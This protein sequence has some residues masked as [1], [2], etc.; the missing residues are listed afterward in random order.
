MTM[1]WPLLPL[2]LVI[3]GYAAF[4]LRA[5]SQNPI[6]R[7]FACY[8]ATSALWTIGIAGVYSGY[9]VWISGI[10]TFASSTLIP[11]SML[12]F[13][14]HYP[15]RSAA[16]SSGLRYLLWTV[17]GS[18][19]VLSLTTGLV[20]SDVQMV[21]G[22]PRRI[23]GTLHPL[24]AVYFVITSVI[25]FYNLFSKWRESR[26]LE[27]VQLTYLMGASLLSLAG[28]MVTNLIH[29]LVAGR[30]NYGWLGPYFSLVFIGV[31]GHAVVRHRLFDIRLVIHKGLTFAVAIV[32]SLVPVAALLII[33][34]RRLSLH[35]TS[36]ELTVG[37]TVVLATSLIIP[38]TRDVASRL[39]NRYVYRREANY[40]RTVR[41]ASRALTRVLQLSRLV[42]FM[43][44]TIA[45]AVECEGVSLYVRKGQ[46]LQ[47]G[48]EEWRHSGAQFE[49]PIK[50][51]SAILS[52]LDV[53]KD[54]VVTDEL[55]RELRSPQATAVHAELTRLDW[56]LVLPAVSENTVIGAIVLGPKRSG[57][58]Y[59]PHDLDLLMTLANQ[60]GIA[61]KNA[62]LYAQVVLANEYLENILATID[63]GVVAVDADGVVAMFNP[64]AERL[65]GLTYARVNGQPLDLLPAGLGDA[66][67]GTLGDG[68]AR[69]FPE[70]ELSD[71]TTTRPVICTASPLRDPDGALLGAVAVLGDLTPV[72]ELEIERRRVERLAYIETFA[73]GIAHEVKNPLV[74]IKTFAQLIP[75]RRDDQRFIDEFS[76]VVT[77]EIGRMERLVERLRTLSRPGQRP[78]HVLDVRQP[79]V[80]ALDFMQA[81][82][83][84]KHVSVEA[85]LGEAEAPVLGDGHE[86]EQLF[87][88]LL[89]NANEATPAEGRITIVVVRS[90][91]RV[92]VSVADSGPGIPVDALDRVFDPFFTTK[93]RGSGLGLAICAG[94]ADSHGA[95]LRV[96]NV[97]SGGARF[98][99]EFPLANEVTAAVAT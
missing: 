4:V 72:R 2:A 19:C 14:D 61:I 74:A 76:R 43:Q 50:M 78:H 1:T 28:G 91:G 96:E 6:N 89:M 84:D 93:E 87:L 55:P 90:E 9:M 77:R 32:V 36:F 7:W 13:I 40:Q 30:S 27:R 73:A 92:V 38:V 79:L 63:S 54:F 52:R 62:Q 70:L 35:L 11:I 95:R 47:R 34:G 98:T 99:V 81:S 26:G 49:V 16:I 51:P 80:D 31:T 8:T 46:D 39:L 22:L 41:E 86:I 88:N 59:Y 3:C 64:A 83:E 82:F 85:A 68:H 75:R 24:F 67:R 37:V 29:P 25:L 33:A 10:F 56:A 18:L 12:M 53:S 71:G 66:L 48:A 57:D 15:T 45:D 20:V 97:I 42:N 60:A 44:N 94:I 65:T 5:N 69:T 21:D 17:A 23:P 58:P